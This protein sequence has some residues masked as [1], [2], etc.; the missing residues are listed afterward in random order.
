MQINYYGAAR[1]NT[2]F[3]GSGIGA[4]DIM[5]E[6]TA[7]GGLA[8]WGLFTLSIGCRYPSHSR[9]LEELPGDSHPPAHAGSEEGNVHFQEGRQTFCSA[10]WH[11]RVWD[12]RAPG[13]RCQVSGAQYPQQG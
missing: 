9:G 3:F 6:A 12:T 5:T 8:T 10:N 2:V 11:D 7:V 1:I 4:V 13:R